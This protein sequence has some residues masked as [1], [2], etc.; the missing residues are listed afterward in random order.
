MHS[1][2][3]DAKRST[4]RRSEVGNEALYCRCKALTPHLE[5]TE[6]SWGFAVLQSEVRPARTDDDFF[7]LTFMLQLSHSLGFGIH[8]V[9]KDL[10]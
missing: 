4:K 5:T 10:L 3:Q 6:A 2:M 1:G 7:L 8:H 9:P